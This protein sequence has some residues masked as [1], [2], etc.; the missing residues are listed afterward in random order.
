MDKI[1]YVLIAD[2]TD[3]AA[4]VRWLDHPAAVLRDGAATILLADGPRTATV[5]ST[6]VR[7]T[8]D[9]RVDESGRPYCIG[10]S[11]SAYASDYP[12]A[13]DCTAAAGAA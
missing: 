9:G 4:V 1:E 8:I 6:L 3:H 7:A 10:H 11:D 5:G 12:N 13:V 2:D